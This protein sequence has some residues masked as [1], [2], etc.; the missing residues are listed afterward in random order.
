MRCPN[1][2]KEKFAVDKNTGEYYCTN[3][4][5]V[6]GQMIDFAHGRERRGKAT[7]YSEVGKG[8]GTRV[9]KSLPF[10]NKLRRW[11][12][13]ESFSSKEE[14]SFKRALHVLEIVWGRLHL[15]REIKESSSLL[16]RYCIKLRLTNGRDAYAMCFAAISIVLEKFGVNRDIYDIA[17][18]FDVKEKI[19]KR[20]AKVIKRSLRI[21]K[22]KT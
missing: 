2:E 7:S 1:C 22:N 19:V 15:D 13:I 20:Y 3:C 21:Y 18:D 5:F 9:P 17:E 6:I 11:H 4:G 12:A 10:Y 14:R 8:L 16:Y